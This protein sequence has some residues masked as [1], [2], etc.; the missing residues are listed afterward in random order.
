MD[1]KSIIG[2]ILISMALVSLIVLL[3]LVALPLNK[4]QIKE[5][6]LK[7]KLYRSLIDYIEEKR[8]K[9]K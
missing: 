4:E 8:H 6:Q 3:F 9:L 1:I 7:R 5:T 2:L